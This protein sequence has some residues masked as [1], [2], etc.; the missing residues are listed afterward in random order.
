[1]A[2]LNIWPGDTTLELR[3]GFLYKDLAQAFKSSNRARFE[4]YVQS[5]Q[6]LFEGLVERKLTK[7]I[8]ASA[9]NG[10]GNMHL[11]RG[12]FDQAVECSEKAVKLFPQYS[13]AWSDLFMGYQGQAENGRPNLVGMRRAF[14]RLEAT[15]GN[16]PLL[17]GV[18]PQ[19]EREL[20]RWEQGS[21]PKRTT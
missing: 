4:R 11:L 9:W 1:M 15:A 16:D 7:E 13:Y 10:L 17:S 12:N 5:G 2:L 6:Q 3:L 19:Y 20:R 14:E 18:I 8:A 21:R